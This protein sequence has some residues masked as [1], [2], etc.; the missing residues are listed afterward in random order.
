MIIAV[1]I[2]VDDGVLANERKIESERVKSAVLV[3]VD[4]PPDHRPAHRAKNLFAIPVMAR[5]FPERKLRNKKLAH[6]QSHIIYK[7][8]L[9]KI[10][11]N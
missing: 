9:V 2:V 7:I 11:D 8:K 1:C 3:V 10:T 6:T 4:L 5:G